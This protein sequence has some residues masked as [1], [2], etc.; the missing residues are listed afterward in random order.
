LHITPPASRLGGGTLSFTVD[1]NA[2]STVS[3]S[4][5]LTIA[6]QGVTITQAGTTCSYSL[7]SPSGSVPFGG[8]SGSASLIA[9]PVCTWTAASGAPSWL[10]ISNTSGSGGASIGYTAQPNAAPTPRSA[11]VTITGIGQ[12]VTYQV[13]QPGTPC[14][15]TLATSGTTASAAGATGSFN[16]S[17]A[18]AGCP[19]PLVQSFAGWI[20]A[21]STFAG[22]SGTA[23]FTVAANSGGGPRTGTIQVNDR[24][25][26]ISQTGGSCTYALNVYGAWFN[27]AGGPG[28]F[29][30]SQNQI[31]CP[32]TVVANPEITLAPWTQSGNQYTQDYTVAPYVSLTPWTRLLYI[33]FGGQLFRVKQ[34]SW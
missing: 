20:T 25:F 18:T 16:F 4:A 7:G 28:S 31:S 13:T 33:D 17:T 5:T 27:Q 29:V 26:T 12:T 6:G 30:G 32:P 1:S 10:S 9:A 3:R 15:V 2:A 8:G 11:T 19:A 24:T 23:N 21:T 34:S 22:T 14:P